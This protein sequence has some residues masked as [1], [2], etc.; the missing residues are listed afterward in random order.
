MSDGPR[1]SA[2]GLAELDRDLA[3]AEAAIDRA[4]H[5]AETYAAPD[6]LESI[7]GGTPERSGDL[8]GSERTWVASNAVWFEA[9]MFYASFVNEGTRWTS[10]TGKLVIVPPNPFVQ[11]GIDAERRDTLA[12]FEA[13]IDDYTEG[14]GDAQ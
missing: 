14:F 8:K 2:I 10:S 4:M 7:R 11:R 6:V 9:G 13:A 3:A 5:Q 12:T 1:I